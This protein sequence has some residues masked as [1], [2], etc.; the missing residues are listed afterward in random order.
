MPDVPVVTAS[1]ATELQAMLHAPLVASKQMLADC[2]TDPARLSE[3]KAKVASVLHADALGKKSKAAT[4]TQ[5]ELGSAEPLR[6]PDGDSVVAIPPDH[7]SALRSGPTS[8]TIS[9]GLP[10]PDPPKPTLSGR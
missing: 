6:P 2:S 9:P 4:D 7:R 10:F 3:A 1:N 5:K 8:M